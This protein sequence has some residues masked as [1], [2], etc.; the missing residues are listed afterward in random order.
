LEVEVT[1]MRIG[2]LGERVGVNPKT[3]RYYEQIGL[4]P[5]PARMASGYRSYGDEDAARLVFVKTAQRLGMTLDEIG[6]ILALRDGGRRPCGYVRGVLRREV[7][8]LDQRIAE[9]RRLRQELVRLDALAAAMAEQEGEAG[10]AGE[11]ICPLIEG[12]R[13]HVRQAPPS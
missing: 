9:L 13:T 11:G 3:I 8:E 4:L 10:E 7:T 6:E 12:G 5:E 2:E 1:A